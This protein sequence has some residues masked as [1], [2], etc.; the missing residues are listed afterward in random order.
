MIRIQF[1]SVEVDTKKLKSISLF[2][3]DNIWIFKNITLA[4][5]HT[6]VHK[7]ICCPQYSGI[8]IPSPGKL[9]DIMK[10]QSPP[11]LTSRLILTE[12]RKY[13]I[14]YHKKCFHHLKLY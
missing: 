13:C 5:T 9:S 4:L 7:I 10:L 12:V 14:D 6:T 11:L 2:K 1:L 3:K 8:R